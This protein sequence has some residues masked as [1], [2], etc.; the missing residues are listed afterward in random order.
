MTSESDRDLLE[1]VVS[2]VV[3]G[4]AQVEWVEPADRWSAHARLR[5]ADGHVS[6]VLTSPEWQEARF[7]EPRCCVVILTSTDEDETREALE[8]L[9]RAA[10]EY[11][12][13]RGHVERRKG[14]LGT[15]PVLVLRT[16]EG[17]WRIGKRSGSIPY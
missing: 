16:T 9:A 17:E 3:G 4:A 15:R 8:K 10:V 12:S 6:H 2:E 14:L 13:G 5:G 7:D 1:Q 11:S